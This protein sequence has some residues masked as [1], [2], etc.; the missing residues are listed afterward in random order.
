MKKSLESYYKE[1]KEDGIL[2]NGLTWIITFIF[3]LVILTLSEVILSKNT[4][5]ENN[6]IYTI[7]LILII[8][9]SGIIIAKE[10]LDIYESIIKGKERNIRGIRIRYIYFRGI[11]GFS[12]P[13]SL[14]II[15][16]N[17][18]SGK[19]S[20]SSLI[21]IFILYNIIGIGLG[22]SSWMKNK[23]MF[24]KYIVNQFHKRMKKINK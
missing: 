17:F 20:L 5:I 18:L 23:D 14:F 15:S 2:I 16:I 6:I 24:I 22:I 10:E 8:S 11:L 19:A 1:L 7:F 12:L 9:C 21:T 3:Y 4:Y 13:I